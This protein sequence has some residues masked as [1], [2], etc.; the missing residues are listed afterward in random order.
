MPDHLIL[1][2]ASILIACL[3]I[4]W[5]DSLGRGDRPPTGPPDGRVPLRVAPG[6]TEAIADRQRALADLARNYPG[7]HRRGCHQ[8]GRTWPDL[9]HFVDDF[10][11][12]RAVIQTFTGRVFCST[13]KSP[14]WSLYLR[15]EG[16]LR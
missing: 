6:G 11:A 12:G 5:I 2:L 4:R 3:V 13:T 15:G 9:D 14:C 8:C 7:V 10:L 16:Q 1:I